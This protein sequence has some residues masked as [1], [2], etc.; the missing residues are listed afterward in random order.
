[1]SN[2]DRRLALQAGIYISIYIYIYVYLYIHVD[3]YFSK[4]GVLSKRSTIFINL[5]CTAGSPNPRDRR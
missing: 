3:I 5:A 1:M 4:I 2:N